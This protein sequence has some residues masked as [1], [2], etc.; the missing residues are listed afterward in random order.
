METPK[1]SSAPDEEKESVATDVIESDTSS[2]ESDN[3]DDQAQSDKPDFAALYEQEKKRLGQAEFTIQKLRKE[4]KELKKSDGESDL[5]V[6]DPEDV[7]RLVAEEARVVLD[8]ERQ[9]DA[10]DVIEEELMALTDNEDERKFI[11]L[12]YEKRIQK[13][14]FSRSAVRDDLH[15][16]RDLAN[17]PRYLKYAHEAAEALKAR[18]SVGKTALGTSAEKAGPTEDLSKH[19][20]QHDWTY[21]QKQGWDEAKIRKAIALKQAQ[22]A[23]RS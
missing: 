19:F 20:S 16:A 22:K 6:Y 12:L 3:S 9:R 13:T 1:G 7:K 14:G 17:A 23:Q 21:I 8:Q 18:A 10:A 15:A 2:D 11:H 5:P 4:N